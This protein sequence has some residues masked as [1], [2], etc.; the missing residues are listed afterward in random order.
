MATVIAAEVFGL[1]CSLG[2]YSWHCSG[3]NS[4]LEIWNP[5]KFRQLAF[6]LVRLS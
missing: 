6:G 4:P 3:E 1:Y 5:Q 2:D